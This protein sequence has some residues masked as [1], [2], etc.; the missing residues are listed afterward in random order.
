MVCQEAGGDSKTLPR[1]IV[2]VCADSTTLVILFGWAGCHDRYLKKYADY[3]EKSGIS[4]ARYTTPIRK[5]R[6]Y[7]SYRRFAK[8]FYREMIEK[9]DYMNYTNIYFHLFSMNGCSTFTALWDFLDNKPNGDDFKKR[10]QGILFDSS[11]AFTTP[12]QN[13]NAISFASMPPAKYHAV[14]RQSYRAVLYAYFSVHQCL[15]WMWSLM[16]SDIYER[17]FAY[18]RMLSLMD[19][20][21]RQIYFYGPGDDVCSLESIEAFA[22]IQEQRGVSTERR[23]WKDSLHCQHYRSHGDEYERYC[24][25]FVLGRAAADL[26]TDVDTSTAEPLRILKPA[27]TTAAEDDDDERVPLCSS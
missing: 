5:V 20:P 26:V 13:A 4:T 6:R 25:E 2:N 11:P 3:Y 9:N 1:V 24:I 14:F 18:Y 10:V 7:Q 19:L 27:T 12:A 17:C 22:A 23:M 15:I 16:E 8:K 21:K